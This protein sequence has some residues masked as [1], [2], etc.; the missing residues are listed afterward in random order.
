MVVV[1][2]LGGVTIRILLHVKHYT[3]ASM[4]VYFTSEPLRALKLDRL[5]PMLLKTVETTSLTT[6]KKSTSSDRQMVNQP[7][8]AA[9]S[10]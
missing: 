4:R 8:K 6:M 2:V 3:Q 5:P 1:K 9:R 10:V 7:T